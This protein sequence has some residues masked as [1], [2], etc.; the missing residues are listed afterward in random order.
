MQWKLLATLGRPAF[1]KMFSATR[2]GINMDA[3]LRERKVAVI[4]GG[5]QALGKERMRIFVLFS[6][7]Q[8]WAAAKRR[9]E[10]HLAM[11]LVDEAS[12]AFQSTII[13][14]ILAELRGYGCAFIGLTQHWA[15]R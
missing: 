3:F 7:G 5:E 6:I 11:C 15:Q 14:D 4:N 9:R 12:Y 1:K 8:Y 10:D 13:A 2:N